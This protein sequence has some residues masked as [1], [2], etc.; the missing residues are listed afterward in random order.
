MTNML[1]TSGFGSDK[2]YLKGLLA[3]YIDSEK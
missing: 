1:D 2:A 3:V